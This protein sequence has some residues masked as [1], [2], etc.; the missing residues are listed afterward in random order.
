MTRE[1]DVLQAEVERLQ[2]LTA[3]LQA[4]LGASGQREVGP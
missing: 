4:T 1:R 3:Q 2:R